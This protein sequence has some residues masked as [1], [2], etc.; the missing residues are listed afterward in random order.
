MGKSGKIRSQ[1]LV[2]VERFSPSVY[3]QCKTWIAT[4]SSPLEIN[5]VSLT[6]QRESKRCPSRR[7]FWKIFTP[8]SK[9]LTES[10]CVCSGNV[11]TCCCGHK[12]YIQTESERE[13]LSFR[14]SHT[15]AWNPSFLTSCLLL[16]TLFHLLF[17]YK[18]TCIP[19]HSMWSILPW[20]CNFPPL[21]S[22]SSP[23]LQTSQTSA[24]SLPFPDRLIHTAVCL[25]VCV[26]RWI[27][28]CAGSRDQWILQARFQLLRWRSGQCMCLITL[29]QA[30]ISLLSSSWKQLDAKSLTLN[31]YEDILD[32]NCRMKVSSVPACMCLWSLC[33][34]NV[35]T[36][37]ICVSLLSVLLSD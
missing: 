21:L 25:R 24:L 5:P 35:R 30:F 9:S 23:H 3:S 18:D 10:C 7:N 29:V 37:T 14:H 36:V 15:A 13:V 17:S 2:A 8:S 31:V 34:K 32:I 26:F 6:L 19:S 33:F 27:R 20:S 11:L 12:L 1:S 16:L 4:Q 28:T 22:L